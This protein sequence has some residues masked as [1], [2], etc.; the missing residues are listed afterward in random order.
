[1]HRQWRWVGIL[2]IGLL[3]SGFTVP[4]Q[5]LSIYGGRSLGYE[6]YY[7]RRWNMAQSPQQVEVAFQEY[8]HPGE[9]LSLVIGETAIHRQLH[10]LGTPSEVGRTLLQQMVAPLGY[11]RQA[12]LISA[13]D[14]RVDGKSYY[15]L[16]ISVQLPASSSSIWNESTID[17]HN[18]ASLTV[19]SGTIYTFNLS[20][21]EER[22]S[23]DR[24]LFKSV[25]NSFRV[26]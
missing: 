16:E 7:P 18:L 24:E 1:M 20:V 12:H 6:F 5:G 8:G 26:F 10:D 11:A 19:D 3:I 14:H 17:R 2:M 4:L 22:W 9:N 21:S 23:R 13:Q 25:V 15:I